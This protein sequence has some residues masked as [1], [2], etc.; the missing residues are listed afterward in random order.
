M[1]SPCPQ[2]P[3]AIRFRISVAEG[4]LRYLFVL[5]GPVAVG[6]SELA[7]QFEERFGALCISTRNVLLENGV[8]N[9]RTALIE[10]GVALDASTGGEWVASGLRKVLATHP[11]TR[12]VVLDSVRRVEQ[13]D[14]LRAAYGNCVVHVMSLHQKAC[15]RRATRSGRIVPTGP[16]RTLRW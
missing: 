4:W 9:E 15:S 7:Q 10:G 6:K 5:S 12:I 2:V 8:A 16:L 11:P 13:I 14:H 3:K 1:G